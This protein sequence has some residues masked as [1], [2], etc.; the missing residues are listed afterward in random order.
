MN[1]LRRIPP[2]AWVV[3]LIGL[4]AVLLPTGDDPSGRVPFPIG[5]IGGLLVVAMIIVGCVAMNQKPRI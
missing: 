4:A 3:G 2:L 1:R 5:L